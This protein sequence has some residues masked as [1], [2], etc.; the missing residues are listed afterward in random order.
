VLV[1]D[2]VRQLAGPQRRSGD[3]ARRRRWLDPHALWHSFISL[4]LHE[5]RSVI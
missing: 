3:G 5:G 4:L 1:K 2:E